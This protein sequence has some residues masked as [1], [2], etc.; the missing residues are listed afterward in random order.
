MEKET[1]NVAAAQ[2]GVIDYTNQLVFD[3]TVGLVRSKYCVLSGNLVTISLAFTW[4]APEIN[5][6]HPIVEIPD[7]LVFDTAT[8]IYFT[9]CIENREQTLGGSIRGN[10]LSLAKPSS[11]VP[12]EIFRVGV[13]YVKR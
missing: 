10:R 11:S 5:G 12:S 7:D 3:Q 2:A 1:K 6:Y 8:N 9:A 4:T 13:T